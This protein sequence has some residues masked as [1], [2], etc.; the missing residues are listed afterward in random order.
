MSDEQRRESPPQWHGLVEL[1]MTREE[2]TA[3]AWNVVKLI[4]AVKRLGAAEHDC[5]ALGES[6]EEQ[7]AWK[8]IGQALAA[9][10]SSSGDTPR[11][12]ED[13][14]GEGR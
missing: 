6:E 3:W 1:T 14:K 5:Y 11:Q 12:S 7:E 10:E 4:Q 13:T 2:R 9:L 8:D